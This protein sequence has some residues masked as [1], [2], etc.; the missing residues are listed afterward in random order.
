MWP[1]TDAC[2]SLLSNLIKSLF[3]PTVSLQSKRD[4]FCQDLCTSHRKG[5]RKPP[6]VRRDIGDDIGDADGDSGLLTRT[7][8]CQQS[9][10]F[11]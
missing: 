3:K 8:H 2:S 7:Q 9:V 10:S 1:W 4:A 5:L 11:H 6:P